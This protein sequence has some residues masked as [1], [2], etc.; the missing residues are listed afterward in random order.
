MSGMTNMEPESD[1]FTWKFGGL[2]KWANMGGILGL[3]KGALEAVWGYE[4]D[5]RS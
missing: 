4:V 2:T 5:L 1:P 3:V